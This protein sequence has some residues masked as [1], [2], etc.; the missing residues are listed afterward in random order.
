MGSK[1]NPMKKFNDLQTSF[2]DK[3]IWASLFVIPKDLQGSCK[4]PAKYVRD[5]GMILQG[6]Q[7]CCKGSQ[8]LKDLAKSCKNIIIYFLILVLNNF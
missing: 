3:Y 4:K 2:P 5:L 8:E 1:N 7:D 6:P